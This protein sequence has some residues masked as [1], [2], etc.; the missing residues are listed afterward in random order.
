[1]VIAEAK[2]GPAGMFS[3]AWY[4]E[5]DDPKDSRRI[6]VEEKGHVQIR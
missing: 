4:D 1:M 6:G 5:N 3:F 2:G